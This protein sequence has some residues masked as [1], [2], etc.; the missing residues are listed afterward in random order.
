MA[1][2]SFGQLPPLRDELWAALGDAR[3]HGQRRDRGRRW[4]H[5]RGLGAGARSFVYVY[6]GHG[7]GTGL[8][9]GG[10][11]HPGLRGNAG[12]I[13]HIQVDPEGPAVRAAAPTAASPST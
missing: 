3:D 13:S 10:E 2:E 12:E 9:L 1:L 8:I 5:W 4:E 6:M 7:L 11:A